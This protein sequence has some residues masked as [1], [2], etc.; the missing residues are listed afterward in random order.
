MNLKIYSIT[1]VLAI[2]LSGICFFIDYRIS[3]GILLAGSF[4]LLNMFLLSVTM[5]QAMSDKLGGQG[6][7]M[8]GSFI[9]FALLIGV[10]Y[11]AVRNQQLFS[12]YGLLI[13]FTLFMIALV[14]DALKRKE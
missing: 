1:A 12:V 5:K 8:G 6:L 2:V 9:R 7:L 3:L 14:I 11:I 10:L 4:S 13:G